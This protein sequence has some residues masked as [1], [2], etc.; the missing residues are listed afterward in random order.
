MDSV[1]AS[2]LKL[3]FSEL[4]PLYVRHLLLQQLLPKEVS[5]WALELGFRCARKKALHAAKTVLTHFD[6]YM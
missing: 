3:C 4:Q 5:L 1:E 6:Y 2:K